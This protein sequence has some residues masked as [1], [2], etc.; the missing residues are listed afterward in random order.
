MP[1]KDPNKRAKDG[2]GAYKSK[3]EFINGGIIED[4]DGNKKSIEGYNKRTYDRVTFNMPK[5]YKDKLHAYMRDRI[6]DIKTLEDNS[7]RTP[8]QQE[9]LERLQSMYQLSTRGEPSLN[10]LIIKL[11]EQETGILSKD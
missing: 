9:E 8:E 11:L 4:E 5:G 1:T 6:E 2:A 7:D 3:L 10:T